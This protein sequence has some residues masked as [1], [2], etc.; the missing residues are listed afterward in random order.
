[1]TGG[2]TGIGFEIA[3]QM[4]Q[5]GHQ[6]TIC[7]RR[8]KLVASAICDIPGI[9]G[10]AYDPGADDGIARLME[11]LGASDPEIP[12][13]NA[14]IQVQTDLVTTGADSL[15]AVEEELRVNLLALIKLTTLLLLR[16]LAG[17]DTAV[18]NLL[19]LLAIMPK[20]SAPGYCAS[21]GGLYAFSQSLRVL[22]QDRD[23]YVHV[24]FPPLVDTPMS[25]RRG[26]GK[27][28]PAGFV[29][30]ML[31]QLEAGRLDVWVGQARTLLALHRIA[32]AMA[33]AWTH[34]VS[35]ASHA[36]PRVRTWSDSDRSPRTR[37]S[38]GRPTIRVP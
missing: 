7:G 37:S 13:N 19:S 14:T 32:P 6:V 2:A 18:V 15:P 28:S 35:R 20:A 27:M 11:F 8:P 21:E 22:L 36:L 31:R 16:L 1:M 33:A 9:R 30:D 5:R 24:V 4:R 29:H 10:I 25:R 38:C 34:R 26:H 17:A 12:V 23:I 3:R